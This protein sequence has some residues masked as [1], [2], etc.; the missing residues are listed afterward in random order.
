MGYP[1][2]ESRVKRADSTLSGPPNPQ[3]SDFGTGSNTGIAY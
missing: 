1:V 2:F 3:D